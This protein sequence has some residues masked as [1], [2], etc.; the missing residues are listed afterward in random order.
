MGSKT[1]IDWADSSWN[2]VTGCLHGCEYCYARK[3]A[4][5]FGGF[6]QED[7]PNT[8]TWVTRNTNQPPVAV[9]TAP[10]ERRD[11]SGMRVSAPYPLFFMPTL[12]SYKLGEP[13][14]WT[15]GRNIFVCSM[16]DLFGEWVPDEWIR[17]V[18]E[19][20]QIAFQ[21]RYLFLTK[22][23]A[24]YYE[25]AK[26]WKLPRLN[27]FWYG[28]SI[29]NPETKYFWS[30]LHH[31]FLSIE[32]LLQDFGESAVD[33]NI[34]WVIIGAETGNRKDRVRPKKEWVDNIVRACDEAGIPVFMKESLR[35][36]MGADFRQEFPWPL[37]AEEES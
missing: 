17:M 27:A 31:C 23:P 30:A 26:D 11:K 16:A 34:E 29:T 15:K 33:P 19:A 18:F 35:A 24:R 3:I 13:V 8:G 21:H 10:Q 25:L 9:F 28:T 7:N 20:C 14:R 22:N 32:P 36:L 4:H 5:R 37:D 1:K 6:I 2:P 12:H